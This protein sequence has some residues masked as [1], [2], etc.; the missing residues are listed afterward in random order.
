MTAIPPNLIEGFQR[1]REQHFERNDSL[2]QQLVNGRPNAQDT[3]GRVLRFARRSGAGASIA[4]RAI[5]S[6]SATWPTW[7]RLLEGPRGH[8]GTTAAIEY[9]V[10]NLGVEHIIVLGHAHCG[11]IGALVASGGV[12]NPGSLHRRLDVPG[13]KCTRRR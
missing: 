5:F 8:H 2:Y 3:G 4:N 11:G 13:G 12:S 1:F 9:G 7:F 10:R 6:S